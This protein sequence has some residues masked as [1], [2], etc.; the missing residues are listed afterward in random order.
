M[1]KPIIALLGGGNSLERKVSL[2]TSKQIQKALLKA[3]YEIIFYDPKTDLIKLTE[4]WQANRFDIAIPALHGKG[5]EDGT[6]QGFLESLGIPYVFSGVE[7]SSIAMNKYVTTSIAK[8]LG[9]KIAENILISDISELDKTQA[10]NLNLPLVIKPNH[11]GSSVQMNI[12][13][14]LDNLKADVATILESGDQAL[15]ESFI[16]G[17]ELTVTILGNGAT[18][19][20]MPIIEILPRKNK[21]YD[22][23]SKYSPGGSEHICP[24]KI[25]SNIADRAQAQ[26]L[27]I[28]RQ[29]NIKDLARIDFIY[30]EQQAEIYFLEVNT[31]PGMT[32]TSLAPESASKVGISFIELLEKLINYNYNKS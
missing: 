2:N 31:I 16:I 1:K 24:A 22:Y 12:I 7:A 25:P 10:E 20:A 8:R 15:L 11:G 6:I 19:K 5:G 30:N 28:Y 32:A 9:L 18:S 27:K 13:D 17:R 4:D 14:S 23:E 21:F 29:L 3:E 26:A